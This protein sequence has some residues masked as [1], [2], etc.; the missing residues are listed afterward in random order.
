MGSFLG[1]LLDVLAS[2]IK[3]QARLEAE[4]VFRAIS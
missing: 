3:S 4:I 1:L 2:P